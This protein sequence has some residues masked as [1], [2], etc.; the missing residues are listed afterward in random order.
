MRP[1]VRCAAVRHGWRPGVTR[2][3]YV[4]WRSGCI[5]R[6]LCTRVSTVSALARVC[7]PS[8]LSP[9]GREPQLATVWHAPRRPWCAAVETAAAA[10]GATRL[11]VCENP[12]ATGI[13]LY[14]AHHPLR[15]YCVVLDMYV[16]CTALAR[17]YVAR[18]VCGG[19][20]YGLVA[21][22]GGRA[23]RQMVRTRVARTGCTSHGRVRPSRVSAVGAMHPR[24]KRGCIATTSISIG[25]SAR[26]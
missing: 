25:A 13:Y 26:A 23:P 15:Q 6:G 5:A 3:L 11:S 4:R 21:C 10:R 22:L 14:G 20:R 18:S 16:P 2:A 8:A 24:S 12:F 1:R 19:G 17:E 9:L 7:P